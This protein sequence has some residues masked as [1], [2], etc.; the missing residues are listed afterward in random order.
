MATCLVTGARGFIGKHL[1][2]HLTE[3]GHVIVSDFVDSPEYVFHLAAY[4]AEGQSHYNRVHTYASNMLV[5][6]QTI[7]ACLKA[8]VKRLV[9]ASSAVVYGKQ[10]VGT[11]TE[12]LIPNPQDPYGI[13]K[14]ASELDIRAASEKFGLEYTVFRLHNVFGV[15]QHLYYKSRNVVGV[16]MNQVMLNQPMWL[17]G[18]GS[19][20][21]QFTPVKQAVQM[22]AKAISRDEAKNQIFNAG[23]DCS[24]SVK[25]MA[26]S[27]CLAMREVWGISYIPGTSNAPS[28][29]ISGKKF[30]V[31]LGEVPDEPI[32]Y[33]LREMA[34]WA[35][36]QG[37]G[38]P[39]DPEQMEIPKDFPRL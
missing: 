39:V 20:R 6:A 36:T 14:Y 22:M 18:D 3:L 28:F 34:Y 5:T 24:M 7:N 31:L 37:P 9:F 19:T 15:G 8:R 25:D 10:S 26:L 12:D 27:V 29:R 2:Q 4:V 1:C 32:G 21:L 30:K 17:Y 13:S 35:K 16:F 38:E 33:S 23:S 11:L